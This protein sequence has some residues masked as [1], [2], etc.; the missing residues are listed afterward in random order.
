MEIQGCGLGVDSG[1]FSRGSVWYA[2]H[3]LYNQG[4]LDTQF[5][6]VTAHNANHLTKITFFVILASFE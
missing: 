1:Q 5:Y 2:S 6:S 3:K 4:P